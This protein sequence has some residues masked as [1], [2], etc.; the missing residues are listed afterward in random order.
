MFDFFTFWVRALRDAWAWGWGVISSISLLSWIFLAAINAAD[1]APKL[2]P[3]EK[4]WDWAKFDNVWWLP[5]SVFFLAVASYLFWAPY[6]YTRSIADK[7][8]Q[9][10]E[11]RAGEISALNAEL[12]QLKTPKLILSCDSENDPDSSPDLP[13]GGHRYFRAVIK[14][15]CINGVKQSNG[16][17]VRIWKDGN[18]IWHENWPLCYAPSQDTDT[19]TKTISHEKAY[20]LDVLAITT[21]LTVFGNAKFDNNLVLILKHPRPEPPM[22]KG[23]KTGQPD[24][25]LFHAYGFGIYIFDISVSG[26]GAVTSKAHLEFN[27]TGDWHTAKLTKLGDG[28]F[29]G[30]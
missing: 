14:T 7:L 22:I 15:P 29:Q 6:K 13:P 27:W 12:R 26:E 8:R 11:D 20:P 17:L 2:A 4:W 10:K 9:E 28:H 25:L 1:K 30:R 16:D 21:A 18:D 19:R 23:G 5:P 24:R 3:Y